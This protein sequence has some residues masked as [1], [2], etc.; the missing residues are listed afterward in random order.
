MKKVV[1][2]EA[3]LALETRRTNAI[4]NH[5]SRRPL[6]DAG[7]RKYEEDKSKEFPESVRR[8]VGPCNTY[9][10]HGLT[11]AARRTVVPSR[12]VMKILE[13]DDYFQIEFKDVVVGDV[14]VYFSTTDGFVEAEHSGIFVEREKGQ[15]G[16]LKILSK[17]GF[18]DERIHFLTECP[19]DSQDV[20]YFRI[21]D[22]NGPQPGKRVSGRE[23]PIGRQH[24][25]VFIT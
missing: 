2:P 11:F 21:N 12:E 17:W 18:A 14:V 8:W 23:R 16:R 15:L 6:D 24:A 1:L 25:A 4:I 22:G 7:A 19:Y 9:N 13:D 10:C 20:S 5:M 3:D